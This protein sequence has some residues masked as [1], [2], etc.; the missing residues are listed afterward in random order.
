MEQGGIM[1][2]IGFASD[3][4]HGTLCFHCQ[5]ETVIFSLQV[6]VRMQ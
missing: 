4:D 1:V 3:H 6:V 2:N 5:I